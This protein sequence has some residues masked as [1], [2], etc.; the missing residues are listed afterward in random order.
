MRA[1]AGPFKNKRVKVNV[2][3]SSSV[4]R[5]T[6]ARIRP[7]YSS[8]IL[9]IV[10]TPGI[11][12]LSIAGEGIDG[13]TSAVHLSYVCLKSHIP[14]SDSVGDNSFRLI[15]FPSYFLANNYISLHPLPLPHSSA[16]QRF[17]MFVAHMHAHVLLSN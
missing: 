6:G 13:Y 14:P 8:S 16:P 10:N 2:Y 12:Q 1:F 11:L 3:S 4:L 9:N 17:L 7:R 15:L 5:G